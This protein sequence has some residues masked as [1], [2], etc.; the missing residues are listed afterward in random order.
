MLT[1]RKKRLL[2]VTL[3]TAFLFM[4]VSPALTSAVL[5]PDLKTGPYIDK[6]VYQVIT[7][8]DATIAALIAGTIDMHSG[9]INPSNLELVQDDPDI[10][11][12]GSLRNGFGQIRIN[13]RDYPL[14]ISGLRRAFAYA[15]DKRA[16]QADIML[17]YSQL[18]DSVVPYT[19]DEWCI[20]DDL[21]WHYYDA[22][23]DTGNA[24]LDDLGFD[25]GPDGWRLAPDG[26]P[27]DFEIIYGA[28]T[29]DIGGGCAQLGVDA[30]ATLD[31]HAHTIPIDFN[32]Y[33]TMMDDHAPYDMIF[34]ATVFYTNDPQSWL[35]Y[36]WSS[37]LADVPLENPSNFV[38]ETYDSWIPQ[39]LESTTYEEVYEASAAMQ[40]ILHYNVP[41][42]IMYE[43]IYM[44]G[45][46]NQVFEGHVADRGRYVDGVWTIR[47]IRKIDGT[48]GGTVTVA[49]G[50][51]PDNFNHYISNS[52]VTSQLLNNMNSRMYDFGPDFSAVP[53]LAEGEPLVEV[54]ADNP[55]V[56]VG[57]Q[58]LTVDL[59]QNATW[60]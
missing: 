56:P 8:N 7:G 4:M 52:A 40:R 42:L 25:R 35:G 48:A 50:V 32:T 38:N 31:I 22:D 27:M 1:N 6:V 5:P 10:T 49:I 51:E 33:T 29:P 54:N 18:H 3:A 12:Q 57:H 26:S 19:F 34:Y 14:N 30:L 21:E 24:I 23:P 55:S 60:S 2:A 9:F 39:F 17:G 47:N 46:R 41:L 45:F 37:W 16:V 15:Y 28:S 59:I 11:L 53:D 43:N 58:R 20:E 44:Q 13:T 36:E